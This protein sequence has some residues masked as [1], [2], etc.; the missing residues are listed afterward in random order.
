MGE[1]GHLTLSVTK[2]YSN[3]VWGIKYKSET[4]HAKFNVAWIFWIYF[5]SMQ[6]MKPIEGVCKG[7]ALWNKLK[8]WLDKSIIF[9]LSVEKWE[10]LLHWEKS[11]VLFFVPIL[12]LK[13]IQ[14]REN[15][16]FCSIHTNKQQLGSQSLPAF[17]LHLLLL[18]LTAAC[19]NRFLLLS[20]P[21]G[22][23]LVKGS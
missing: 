22:S 6:S 14:L 13:G 20:Q 19:H 1:D 16:H 15:S 12:M 21:K 9:L 23:W 2:K 4:W 5:E 7:E 10:H 8:S 18:F 11:S 17:L 3:P